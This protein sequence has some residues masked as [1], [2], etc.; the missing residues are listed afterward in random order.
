MKTKDVVSLYPTLDSAKISKLDDADKFIIIKLMCQFKLIK[1]EF[2]DELQDARDRLKPE[3]Y[4][5]MVRKAREWERDG[6]KTGLS[7]E[8]RI[9]I[10]K[11]FRDYQT[12]IDSYM[13]DFSEKEQTVS[14]SLLGEDAFGK[15]ISSND[16]DL[17]TC[18]DL[19]DLI[20]T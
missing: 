15:F 5:D 18:L 14:C 2:D 3:N 12:S 19:Q 10:N 16:F 6:D 8:E 4:D 1:K 11:F 17:R 20:C 7:V 9:E 13:K